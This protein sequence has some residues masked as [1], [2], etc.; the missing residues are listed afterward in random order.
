MTNA[1]VEFKKLFNVIVIKQLGNYHAVT[2]TS[3]RFKPVFEMGYSIA[4]FRFVEYV[5]G[6][7]IYCLFA[8]H[9]FFFLFI[10]RKCSVCFFFLFLC[11]SHRSTTH[12]HFEWS[13]AWVKLTDSLNRWFCLV[14]MHTKYITTHT[15]VIAFF[16]HR[17]RYRSIL[18]SYRLSYECMCRFQCILGFVSID[19]TLSERE[20]EGET[21][22][23]AHTIIVSRYRSR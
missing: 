3:E 7:E 14:P 20:K 19:R 22:K 2:C 10:S 4:S 17:F 12:T 11:I 8:I 6:G 23:S 21:D 13:V 9:S 5:L 16:E 18:N 15:I 1:N